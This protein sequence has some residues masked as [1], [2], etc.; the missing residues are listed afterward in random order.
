M[1]EAT[2]NDIRYIAQSIINISRHLKESQKTIYSHGLPNSIDDKLLEYVQS[3]IDS[4]NAVSFIYEV[5]SKAVASITAKIEESSFPAAHIGIIGNIS[6]CW[7]DKEYRNR[8]IASELLEAVEKWMRVRGVQELELSY[9]SNNTIAEN[10][11]KKLGFT[12]FRIFSHKRI[13]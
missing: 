12:P 7:V 8:N 3:F 6:T 4:K 2:E 5:D 11:W 13:D 10:A 1:R 9:L